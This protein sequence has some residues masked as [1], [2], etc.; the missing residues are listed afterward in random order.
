MRNCFVDCHRSCRFLERERRV[1]G[2]VSDSLSDSLLRAL[3]AFAVMGSFLY[4]LAW[5]EGEVPAA[6][7]GL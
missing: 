5:R 7:S 2:L 4:L 3:L 6:E 1:T